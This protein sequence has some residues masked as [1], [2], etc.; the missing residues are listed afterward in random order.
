MQRLEKCSHVS[1]Q[2]ASAVNRLVIQREP[3]PRVKTE[4]GPDPEGLYT[5]SSCRCFPSQTLAERERNSR[6]W[7]KPSAHYKTLSWHE[8]KM[9]PIYFHNTWSW[10]SCE[11]DLLLLH[12]LNEAMFT[13][14]ENTVVWVLKYSYVLSYLRDWQPHS[15]TKITLINFQDSQLNSWKICAVWT[16]PDWQ[17]VVCHVILCA[18]KTRVYHAFSCVFQ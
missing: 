7:L 16:E 1:A 15:T 14:Q 18:A 2:T 3:E 11:C 5:H 4:P 17:L 12:V 8:V 6:T 10:F 9:I 13:Q